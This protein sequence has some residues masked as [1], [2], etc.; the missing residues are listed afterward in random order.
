MAFHRSERRR[1]RRRRQGPPSRESDVFDVRSDS[2]NG[3]NPQGTAESPKRQNNRCVSRARDMK[4][5]RPFKDDDE[6]KKFL[7]ACDGKFAARDRAVAGLGVKCGGR[8]SQLL[9][10]RVRDVFRDGYFVERIYFR[11][12]TRKG[13]KEGQSIVFHP[14]LRMTLGRWLVELRDWKG[15]L[16]EN[17]YLFASRKGDRPIGRKTYWAIMAKASKIAHLSPGI[18]THTMRKTVAHRVF[19]KTKSLMV[20]KQV[21][22]QSSLLTVAAYLGWGLDEE[23][24]K[25]VMGL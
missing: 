8:I 4:G 24:D 15:S 22:G 20:T 16:D 25:A 12:A 9:A 3:L 14:T 2:N 23:A 6:I 11:R 7:H 19:Q 10:L 5:A 21:L 18:S 1:R 13:K 17:L